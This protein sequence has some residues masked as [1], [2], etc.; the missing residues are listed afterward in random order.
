MGSQYTRMSFTIVYS[1]YKTYFDL[2]VH[3]KKIKYVPGVHHS[4]RQ[5]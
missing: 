1:T 3:E 2:T 5:L 4:K